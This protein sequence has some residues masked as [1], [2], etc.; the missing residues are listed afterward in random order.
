MTTEDGISENR[1]V[2]IQ[3]PD[4]EILEPVLTIDTIRVTN[5][6]IVRFKPV[7]NAQA[8]L[9]TW[10]SEIGNDGKKLKEFNGTTNIPAKLDWQI[11][12][13]KQ[14]TLASLHSLKYQ[15]VVTDAIG[16]KEIT[17]IDSIPVTQLTL[18]KKREEHILDT[19]FSRYNLILF[20][21]G[22]A[23]LNPANQKIADYVRSRVTPADIATINGYADRIGTPE[24]NQKLSEGR[25]KSTAVAVNLTN[26]AIK[27]IGGTELLY[28]NDIP[29]GRFY[30]RTVTIF[31]ATPKKQ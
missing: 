15:L 3:C 28:D 23:N 6:P 11:E 24:Y 27:G 12:K 13:E 17:P 9:A 8:G 19:V 21:F 14:R 7:V 4:W 25:A 30:C 10:H 18:A 29:E 16:Q 1:R 26:A 31:V 5:P 20:D 2:E 22:K